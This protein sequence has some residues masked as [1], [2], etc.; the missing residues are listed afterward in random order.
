[1]CCSIY[2]AIHTS[3]CRVNSTNKQTVQAAVAQ[4][5]ET[6]LE[7]G[8]CS[9]DEASCYSICEDDEYLSQGKCVACTRCND[10]G[11]HT[12][13]RCT[14]LEDAVCQPLSQAIAAT[15]EPEMT[16]K[17]GRYASA[18]TCGIVLDNHRR[19]TIRSEGGAASTVIDCTEDSGRHFQVKG[20]STLILIGVTLLNG[21]TESMA[22]GGCIDVVGSTLTMF[23]V[24]LSGCTA[25]YGGAVYAS[26][27]STVTVGTGSALTENTA[28][29][30]GGCVYGE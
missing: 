28:I 10:L 12:W 23:D 4:L 30:D 16:L 7:R 6:S 9:D 26:A 1:M 11:Q 2:A 5:I 20:G 18:G 3:S 8:R 13:T 24:A 19:L 14:R 21:G 27:G 25:Q 17:P 22:R 15:T 29:Q